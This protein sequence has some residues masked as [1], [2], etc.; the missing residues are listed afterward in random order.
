MLEL[1]NPVALDFLRSRADWLTHHHESGQLTNHQALIVLCLELLS[2]LLQTS[3][4]NRAKAQ[5]L[6]RVL[7]WQSAEGWFQE[8]E[9]CDPGYHT[10]TISCL[11][12]IHQLRPD[13]RLQE[14]LI[15]AVE[16]AAHFI[17]PDGSFG[18]EYASR[19]TYNFF[20]HGFELVGH[21][22]PEALQISDRFLTGL[23]NGLAPATLTTILLGTILGIIYWLGETLF[24]IDLH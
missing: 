22:M 20:P 6:E 17:H 12:R 3:E 8:Y 16:L 23:A 4:W 10:L 19:N 13:V 1:H 24:P 5:R 21:W 14:A 7:S 11:A 18:G 2:G 9:G 15:K